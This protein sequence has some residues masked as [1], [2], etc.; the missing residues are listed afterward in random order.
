MRRFFL[1]LLPLPLVLI[2]AA[3]GGGSGSSSVSS[4]DAAVVD[5]THITQSELDHQ[6]QETAC[7][8]KLQKKAFPKAGSTSYQALQQQIVQVLVQ[9]VQLDQQAPSLKVSVTDRQ[10]EDQL[11][12]I[13]KQ[14]FGGSEKRYRSELT[15]QCIT[16]AEVRDQIRAGL[17]SDGIRKKLIAGVTVKPADVRAYYDS[18][19]ETY[20]TPQTRVVSHI[21]VKNKALADKLYAQLKGGA[22]F[23][24]LAKKYSL[25]PGSKAN[26]GELTITR[27]QT[28][29]QFDKVAFELRTG[30]LSKPVHTQYGWHIIHADKPA[31]P[32]RSQPFSQVKASIEQQLLQ[33]KQNA[34]LQK[35]LDGLKKQYAGK[36]SYA[37]GLA[38][39]ATTTAATTTG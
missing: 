2:A 9:R 6:M 30:R 24:T 28:V 20:T 31:T 32:H 21:L 33:E 38:P 14:Y 27:G 8:Y 11:K 18:H 7:R 34:A 22:D 39:P 5:G 16:D 13:K 12:N 15:K 4:G 25:D 19:R 26:G 1:V 29:P 23:A 35:W 10:V 37:T 36:I 3:C 17:V